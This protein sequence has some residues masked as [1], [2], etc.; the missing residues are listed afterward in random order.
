MKKLNISIICLLFVLVVFGS[1]FATTET[2]T[3]ALNG[4]PVAGN[5]VYGNLKTAYGQFTVVAAPKDGDIFEMCRIPANATVV[6]GTFYAYDLDAGSEAI[7]MD[8]GWAANG[9]ESA[10]PDGFLN[11]GTLTGDAIT[12]YKPETGT[13]MPFGGVLLS[14]GFHKFT[15]ETLVQIEVN[16]AANSFSTGVIGVIVHYLMD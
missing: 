3:R 6:G 15:R 5:G 7:D 11:A 1:S 9:A 14:S 12:G 4:F 8:I 16:T 10:D 13:I 2:T